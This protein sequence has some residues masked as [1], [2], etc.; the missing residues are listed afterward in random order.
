VVNSNGRFTWYELLTSDIE[1]AKAFYAK[2]VGWSTWDASSPGMPYVL[3]CVGEAVVAGLMGLWDDA[4][5][6]GARPHWMGYVGV[7]D[8]DAVADRIKLCG[9]AVHVPPTDIPNVSRF[10]IFADPQAAALG[11]L[12]WRRPADG[13][14]ADL[15]ARGRVGWHELVASDRMKALAFYS[16]L[17]N[18]QQ[19]DADI[20][21]LGTYQL[22]S[23]GGETIGGMINGPATNP[24]FWLYYFNVGDIDAAAKRVTAGGGRIFDG[25]LELRGGSWIIQC[26]DPQGAAFALEGKRSRR[27]VGYFE[28]LDRAILPA[29]EPGDGPGGT[30]RST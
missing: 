27:P 17:F 8:V 21:A 24:P 18:W 3:F 4:K 10:S 14:P 16:E 2:V 28:R 29:R 12:K 20:G 22:F 7:D 30:G 5:A 9:G 25:P 19:A 11:V 26:A 15:S 23:A 1:G 6:M 13:Q